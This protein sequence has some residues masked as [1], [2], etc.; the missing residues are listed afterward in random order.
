MKILNRLKDYIAIS[1]VIGITVALPV[2][3]VA[4]SVVPSYGGYA[5][6]KNSMYVY[7]WIKDTYG[8]SIFFDYVDSLQEHSI[9]KLILVLSIDSGRMDYHFSNLIN[10]DI[11]SQYQEL[12]C[13]S[14]IKDKLN[15]CKHFRDS[16][17]I[18]YRNGDPHFPEFNST[19]LYKGN[20]DKFYAKLNWSFTMPLLI[21]YFIDRDA[22][23]DIKNK[24]YTLWKRQVESL[25]LETFENRMDRLKTIK[26]PDSNGMLNPQNYSYDDWCIK[27]NFSIGELNELFNYTLKHTSIH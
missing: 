21:P 12:F 26:S 27:T 14:R 22:P 4:F 7:D 8:D 6:L 17:N 10:W 2:L 18:P 5:N 9:Q 25:R 13:D 20:P 23:V 15:N 19:E 16:L 3:S 11:D 1:I 24:E